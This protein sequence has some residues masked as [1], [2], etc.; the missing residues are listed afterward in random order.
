MAFDQRLAPL[1][2][3]RAAIELRQADQQQRV[4]GRSRAVLD[5]GC[6][7][8]VTRLAGRQAQFQKTLFGKQRHAGAGL[9][10]RTPVETGIGGEDLAFVE[11]LLAGGG[12]DCV[13]GFLT[14][15]R[16]VAADHIDRREGTLQVF[17]ELGGSELHKKG[18][19]GR[20]SAP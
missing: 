19:T 15:Q 3:L 9:K 5:E 14:Q 6:S 4:F 17:G 16:V 7:T 20:L 8:F 18:R 10:Q 2:F 12:A 11:T 13:S 1:G